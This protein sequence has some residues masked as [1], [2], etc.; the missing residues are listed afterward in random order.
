MRVEW[1]FTYICSC[2]AGGVLDCQGEEGAESEGQVPI[3]PINH[4]KLHTRLPRLQAAE[5]SRRMAGLC[6]GAGRA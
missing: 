6:L 4:V 5:T 2:N 3:L 1:T